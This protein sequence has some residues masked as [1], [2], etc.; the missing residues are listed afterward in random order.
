MLNRSIRFIKQ[1]IIRIKEDDISAWAAKLTFFILLSIFPFLIFL[2]E[3]IN[4]IT[5]KYTD[6]FY[7]LAQFFPPEIVAVIQNITQ[8]IKNADTS[9]SVLPIAII[10]SIWS[11][12]KGMM[13]IVTSLNMAYKE[14]ETRSYFYLRGLSLLYTVAFAF[15]LLITLGFVVFGNKILQLLMINIPILDEFDFIIDF[16][17]FISSVILS[18][19]FF[20]LLYN[21]TPNRKIRIRDVIPGSLFATTSWIFLS[22]FFSLYVNTNKSFSYMYGSLTSIIILLLWLYFSS[23]IIMIGGELNALISEQKSKRR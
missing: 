21:A 19:L 18:F 1:F 17:R 11:A 12:S 14:K 7:E 3:I 6:S 16:I 8:D 22:Y 5:F 13:A 20:V 4:R 23:T 9:S 2:M 15:I 10:I